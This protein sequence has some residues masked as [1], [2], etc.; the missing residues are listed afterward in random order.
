MSKPIIRIKSV[1]DYLKKKE[2][3]K[4]LPYIDCSVWIVPD[5][6]ITNCVPK[7]EVFYRYSHTKELEQCYHIGDRFIH[8][9]KHQMLEFMALGATQNDADSLKML[10]ENSNVIDL[11]FVNFF[12]N[13]PMV[14]VFEDLVN[15]EI[16][17]RK[18]K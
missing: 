4:G 8:S 13:Q 15:N 12:E 5:N 7:I 2:T 10:I 1:I 3:E 18:L 6:P 14:K 17:K 11:H 9:E 16:E